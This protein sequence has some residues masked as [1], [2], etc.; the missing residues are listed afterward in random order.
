M[1]TLHSWSDAT[2]RGR[3]ANEGTRTAAE[4]LL[5]GFRLVANADVPESMCLSRAEGHGPLQIATVPLQSVEKV[6]QP[7]RFDERARYVRW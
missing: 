5:A 4:S 7:S 1:R 2:D 6:E 3:H